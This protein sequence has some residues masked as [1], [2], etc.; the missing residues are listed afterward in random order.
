M[1]R[2]CYACMHTFTRRQASNISIILHLSLFNFYLLTVPKILFISSTWKRIFSNAFIIP[3]P[4]N[5]IKENKKKKRTKKQL[6]R[7]KEGK[8]KKNDQHLNQTANVLAWFQFK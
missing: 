7:E 4:K 5:M 1:V 2:V 3:G 8:Q 6:L